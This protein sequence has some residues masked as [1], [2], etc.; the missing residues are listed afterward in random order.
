[1]SAGASTR[2]LGLLIVEDSEDDALLDVIA[3]EDAGYDV[4][5]RR[6]DDAQQF[7]VALGQQHWDLVLC[8]HALPR[9]DSFGALR[10][11]SEARQADIPLVVVSGAIGEETAA[12]VIREGAADFVNKS[13]LKRLPTVAAT[14]LRDAR[15][16]RAAAHAE[17]QFRS[18]FDDAAFGSALVDLGRRPGRLLRVNGALCEATNMSCAQLKRTRLQSLVHEPDRAELQTA[19]RAAKERSRSTYQAELRL[20]DSLGEPRWFL[21]SLAPV[22]EPGDERPCAVAQFIE[23][24]ARK[25]AEEALQLA[26]Q[27]ALAA[28]RM[29]SEFMANVSHEIR[30]PLNGVIGLTELLA[31]T[32]LSQEQHDYVDALHTSGHA[33]LSVI[34][35]VLDFSKLEA[36]KVELSTVP[37]R[38]A[39]LIERSLTIVAPAAAD[40][41]L[42]LSS[43]TAP[44]VP[45]LLR[46]D[47]ARILGV[48]T[49][50]LSNAVKFTSRGGK[51]GVE[52]LA[53]EV[54]PQFLR[55]AV[56]DTGIGIEPELRERIFQPFSQADASTSRRF[57]GTGLGLT[58]AKQLVEL[59]GGTIGLDSTLG[60][61]SRFFFQIPCEAIIEGEMASGSA[62]P[63]AGARL[64]DHHE[65]GLPILLAEDDRV[66]RL[67]AERLLSRAGYRVEIACDGH[68]AVALSAAGEY[69]LIFMD[70]Q[71]PGLDG[72]DATRAIRRSERGHD[73]RRHVPIVAMT[74]HAMS[75]DREKCLASGMDDYI[76]KPLRRPEIERV[77]ARFPE[78]EPEPEPEPEDATEPEPEGAAES[79]QLVDLAI[80]S[81]ILADGGAEEGLL[82]LFVD[83]A[84]IRLENLKAAVRASDSQRVAEI[85]HSLHGSCA[86]FGATAMAAAA[87]R[88]CEPNGDADAGAK[89]ASRLQQELERLFDPT[90][91]ALLEA[92]RATEGHDAVGVD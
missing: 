8:D 49:N 36:G 68:E 75:G 74:A 63:G 3:L 50:L 89:Q 55:F 41:N 25:R 31:D 9:F 13:N 81:D 22:R 39:A 73:G 46:G 35:Q 32:S 44:D 2:T 88:L 33:L 28:S 7:A 58:I 15:I 24:N 54:H 23:I 57:G 85:A 60:A 17:A 79:V 20:L 78:S 29:K 92:A 65:P 70:C 90:H 87:R 86:T 67:V 62:Q 59:M 64:S 48:L 80:V 34:E 42:L 30:T 40:K 52:L 6:V 4:N 61:G 82:T 51:V 18:A 76:A 1:M 56:S 16:R 84:R 19:L 12:A 45:V 27:Q 72:Y 71:M 38:P 11:L 5:W 66:N 26:H 91:D 21:V 37:F 43:S 47:P 53:D 10:V 69:R 77:L 14:V 83:Q